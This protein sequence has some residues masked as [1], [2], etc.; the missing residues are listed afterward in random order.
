MKTE[1]KKVQVRRRALEYCI[2]VQLEN[3]PR[4]VGEIIEM[5][6]KSKVIVAEKTPNSRLAQMK[7]ENYTG[8]RSEDSQTQSADNKVHLLWLWTGFLNTDH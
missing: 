1:N 3:N 7:N 5:V 8:R 2:L 4:C 6:K